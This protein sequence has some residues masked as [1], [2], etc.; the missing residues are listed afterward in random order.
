LLAPFAPH[1]TEELWH[2]IGETDSIHLESWPEYDPKAIL[3]TTMTIAVQI[4][5]KVRAEMIFD[6]AM[7]ED[8]IRE[9]VLADEKVKTYIKDS[10]PKKIVYVPQKLISIVL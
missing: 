2:E 8:E 10:I 1:I 5:G 7:T 3:E 4:N 9:K 6:R